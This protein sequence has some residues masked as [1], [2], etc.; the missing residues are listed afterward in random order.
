MSYKSNPV[1]GVVGKIG[2][3]GKRSGTL[4]KWAKKA[5]PGMKWAKKPGIGK[6]KQQDVWW[7]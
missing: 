3:W 6:V 4:D 7:V 5:G 1:T 2:G